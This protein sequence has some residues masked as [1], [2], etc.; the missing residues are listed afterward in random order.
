MFGLKKQKIFCIGANK[1]GTTS[2]EKA[3]I[4]QGF[5]LGNQNKA[6]S[7]IEAYKIRDFS[8]II[9]FC[10]SAD[11]FQ[12]SPFSWH[13]TFMHLDKAFPKS[14]FILT[15]RDTDE[16]W[17]QSFTKFQTKL[18]GENGKLPTTQ[19]LKKS[20]RTKE[21]T[22]W[23]NIQARHETPP[24]DPYKKEILINYYNN[25]NQMVI[26]YFRFKDNLLVINLKQKDA[27]KSFCKFL[28]LKPLY[29]QF[30]WENKT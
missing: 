11:A 9:N 24:N 1:T 28:N 30:P 17:Y 6:Q 26:D 20:F 8:C 25:H 23:D 22:V 10:K 15:V 14:K 16:E 7:L 12:D 18:F 19:Q 2:V 13:Y 27:Y 21:R 29:E 4:D 3:L 5:R